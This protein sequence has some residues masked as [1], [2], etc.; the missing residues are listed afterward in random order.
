[1]KLILH[2][3][4]HK[5]GSTTIQNSLNMMGH[6]LASKYS[7][8][9]PE[10]FLKRGAHHLLPAL[11]L[12][13]KTLF[14]ESIEQSF[15]VLVKQF[16]QELVSKK[17]EIVFIS[18]EEFFRFQDKDLLK[19]K[20]ITTIFDELEIVVYLRN[21]LDG[22]ESSY[23]FNI[24]WNMVQ[25]TSSFSTYLTH[26]LSSDYHC[27]DKK[28]F[29]WQEIFPHA[30]L[31]VRD[32][33]VEIK[34]GLLKNFYSTVL[35][36]KLEISEKK[37]NASLSRLSSLA[38]RIVNLKDYSIKERKECEKVLKK[39]DEDNLEL[40][41]NRLYTP[42]QY[43]Q[44]LKKFNESNII[45]KDCY[46][47]D[48]TL[49]MNNIQKEQFLGDQL[50]MQD[51]LIMQPH[52][53]FIPYF[54]QLLVSYF[55]IKRTAVVIPG[56]L[57]NAEENEYI[58]KM[59]SEETDVF[60]CTSKEHI[61]DVKF[62]GNYKK[63]IYIEDNTF[64]F[65]MQKQLLSLPEGKKLLQ[66]QKLHICADLLENYEKE[67]GIK[68]D[69]ILKLRTDLNF[70]R[71]FSVKDM[72]NLEIDD[73]TIYMNSDITFLSTRKV[74]SKIKGFLYFALS[75]LYNK[76][77]VFQPLNLMNIEKC[78]F[79]AAKFK[80]LNYPYSLVGNVK[81]EQ[82]LYLEIKNKKHEISKI[83]YGK[84]DVFNLRDG[85]EN[86]YFPSEPAFL[87][88]V[89]HNNLIVKKIKNME[90]ELKSHRNFNWKINDWKSVKP[91][92]FINF[93]QENNEN[94]NLLFKALEKGK[95]INFPDK[96]A[97]FFRIKAK[98]Y[99]NVNLKLSILMMEYASMIR[100]KGTLINDK[101]IEYREKLSDE[102]L[103][104]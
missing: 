16:E 88:Y 52:L 36:I 22:I 80:W 66:W 25:E 26:A 60:I 74:F 72:I 49:S 92:D 18:S 90:L 24:L 29:A 34:K 31:V 62:M 42:F 73:K 9:Y 28:L 7:F 48:L 94:Y 70:N 13:D 40:K 58:F 10:S 104:N 47:I 17:P 99:E 55:T 103:S 79:T 14:G 21:Q 38:M 35:G 2:I 39:F 64:F 4:N 68:Y 82:E 19:L 53:S 96:A 83:E 3:G 63:L 50:C 85:F 100:P 102:K 61:C 98:R 101:L 43:T 77:N 69:Y 59:L 67:N 44:V 65:D 95:T 15:E 75:N 87:Y 12:G 76:P 46:N 11:I 23:K 8:L 41:R 81:N 27:F 78:D 37:N 6:T 45:L 32:F 93:I 84:E 5:T 86:I 91:N 89:L 1:M 97:D 20:K 56:L 33:N 30:T 57:R 54:Q 71:T 51:I